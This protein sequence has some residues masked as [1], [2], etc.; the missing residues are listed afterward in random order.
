MPRTWRVNMRV[1]RWLSTGSSSGGLGLMVKSLGMTEVSVELGTLL[2]RVFAKRVVGKERGFGIAV[3]RLNKHAR[4]KRGC[5][6]YLPIVQTVR[7][8]SETADGRRNKRTLMEKQIP[9]SEKSV[10]LYCPLS[11]RWVFHN[12]RV[13]DTRVP[14]SPAQLAVDSTAES[15]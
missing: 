1:F 5:M 15:F 13:G 10:V 12:M 14:Y 11:L 9:A 8:Y 4:L 6:K 2:L 7:L 3:A